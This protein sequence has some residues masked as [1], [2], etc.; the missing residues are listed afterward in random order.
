MQESE[1]LGERMEGGEA[2]GMKSK[3]S[4]SLRARVWVCGT[5]TCGVGAGVRGNLWTGPYWAV[6]KPQATGTPGTQAHRPL[7]LGH[8]SHLGPAPP[9]AVACCA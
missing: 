1:V 9:K 2:E 8:V 3:G 6:A 5:E 7:L 4:G